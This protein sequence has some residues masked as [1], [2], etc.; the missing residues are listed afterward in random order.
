MSIF[1]KEK[2]NEQ[3]RPKDTITE[4]DHSVVV[5]HEILS[6]WHMFHIFHEKNKRLCMFHDK[7]KHAKYN[8]IFVDFLFDLFAVHWLL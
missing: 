1:F 3:Y 8:K 2:Y 7:C 5:L 4:W 6:T